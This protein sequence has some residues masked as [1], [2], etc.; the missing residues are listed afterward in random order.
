MRIKIIR[1][2]VWVLFVI[3]AAALIHLQAFQGRRYYQLSVSNRIRVV[4]MEGQRGR[5]FDRQGEVLAGNR[6]SFN[7]AVVPQ[8]IRDRDELFAFLARVLKTTPDALVKKF[9]Q[10]RQTPFAPVVI[11][12]DIDK[13]T[14]MV[15][16]EN[17]FRFPGLHIQEMFRRSYLFGEIGGH[18]LGYVG[19]IDS[20]KVKKLKDYGYSQQSIV[21]YSGVEEYYDHYLM[22]E[23]G[24]LQIEVNSRGQQVRLLG[25]REPKRGRDIHLTIDTRIQQAANAALEGRAGAVVVMDIDTGEVLGLISAPGFDPNV[26]SED[27]RGSERAALITNANAPMLNRVIKGQYPPGSVFKTVMSVAGLHTGKITPHTTFHCPGFYQLG[28]RR[29]RCAHV[30]YDQNILQALGHSCN[31]FY[32]NLGLILDSEIMYKYARLFGLG[33]KSRIDLPAEENGQVPNKAFRKKKYNLGWFKGDTLN[34]SIGQGDILTTPIQVAR[35]MAI[36]ARNGQMVQP[37]LIRAIDDQ[38]VVQ[39]ATARPLKIGPEIFDLI[40]QGLRFAIVSPQGTARILNMDGF[41]IY[42]KTG[43]AQ[44]APNKNSHAWFAGYN[45]KGIKRVSFCVFLEYGGSSY[46][47]VRVTKNLLTELRKNGVL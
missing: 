8:D 31:V 27:R 19:K 21:G 36:V 13:Q 18:V 12:D 43:T 47:A 44:T 9:T 35:L 32:Y 28:R 5:I 6:L 42:G 22:A 30:H 17:R 38:P 24:G 4:P 10:R 15:L 37:H 23:E 29:F 40:H 26:F 34:F 14:A 16:E 46:Y 2:I 1:I 3:L 39:A 25:I 7:V 11:V 20:A 45:L 33:E 41:E